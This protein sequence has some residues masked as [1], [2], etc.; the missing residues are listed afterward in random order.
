[1][2]D[3]LAEIC[4]YKR[5]H[6]I[7]QKRER[8]EDSLLRDA[9]HMDAPRK[10]HSALKAKA[11]GQQAALI[12]EIK[13]ASPSKGVIREDFNHRSIAET[14]AKHG[15]TC[16]S[17]LTDE[18]YF[19][20]SDAFIA[21]VK[22]VCELPVLRKDFML[23]PYQIVESRAIEADCILLIMAALSDGQ[24]AELFAAAEEL[25]MNVLVEV[26]NREE[27]DRSL[28]LPLH[29][30]GVNNRNLKT[31]EIDLRTSHSL[32]PH[33]PSSVL[34][35]AES[36]IRQHCDIEDLQKSYIYSYLVGESLMSQADIGSAVD[37]LLGK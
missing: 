1:M 31:L 21:E 27:L 15:A 33:I 9:K 5:E 32:A 25:G 34:P 3:I 37:R 19:Q 16:L 22:T 30:L 12:A 35:I 13:K 28:K 11:D 26:H 4:E 7:K 8:A 10:F 14:Y 17:V 23:E 18:R 36:G 24:A 20:G 6:I 2:A 29:M